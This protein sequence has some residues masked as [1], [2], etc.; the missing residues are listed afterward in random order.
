MNINNYGKIKKF[1][2]CSLKK[3]LFCS[4]QIQTNP[5]TN[6]LNRAG[7]IRKIV[8]ILN[9]IAGQPSS[10]FLYQ[11]ARWT[12]T[13]PISPLCHPKRRKVEK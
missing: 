4:S 6:S 13:Y 9:C 10:H 3:K 8:P 11:N 2:F 1:L 7:R 5:Y 12:K